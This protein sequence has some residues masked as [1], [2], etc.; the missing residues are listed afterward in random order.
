MGFIL[1]GAFGIT[2]IVDTS[3]RG[4]VY[5]L[6]LLLH[7]SV[8]DVANFLINKSYLQYCKKTIKFEVR[9]FL[10]VTFVLTL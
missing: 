5:S 1:A 6:L 8:I 7:F 10:S 9:E 4:F 3:S 2:I